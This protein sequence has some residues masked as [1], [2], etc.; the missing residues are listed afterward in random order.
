MSVAAS[1]LEIVALDGVPDIAAGDDLCGVVLDAYRASGLVPAAGDI[2]VIAQKIVS[3]AEGRR[4]DLDDVSPSPQAE[5]L[6]RETDKDARVIELIL[7]ESERVMRARPGLIVVRHRLGYVL[8]NAGIDAS[9]VEDGGDRRVLLLPSDPDGSA[10]AIRAAIGRRTGIALGVVVSDSLGRAWRLGT[11]ATA[12]GAAG[13]TALADLRGRP[14]MFGRPLLVSEVGLADQIASAAALVM[15][16]ADERRPIALL[17]GLAAESEDA[18]AA[19]LIR[20][21]GTDLFC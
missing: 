15:G 11:A 3:K 19:D 13:V 17:R 18:R 20:P 8:A 7:S 12:L 4:V 10:A 6:A 5:R 21:R 1:R 9:N 14:D 2:L 16:E